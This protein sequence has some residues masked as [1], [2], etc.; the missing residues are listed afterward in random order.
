MA[1]LLS[2]RLACGSQAFISDIVLAQWTIA[3]FLEKDSKTDNMEENN[4]NSIK[5]YTHNARSDC[6]EKISMAIVKNDTHE[7]LP[8]DNVE[9]VSSAVHNDGTRKP[10]PLRNRVKTRSS[11]SEFPEQLPV[12]TQELKHHDAKAVYFEPDTQIAY[13]SRTGVRHVPAGSSEWQLLGIESEGPFADMYILHAPGECTNYYIPTSTT[14][15]E[16][17][18]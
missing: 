10:T 14:F 18:K 12:T 5:E 3:K 4:M 17:P 7:S 1:P 9:K 2:I 15:C 11:A 8:A 6:D 13:L 16:S